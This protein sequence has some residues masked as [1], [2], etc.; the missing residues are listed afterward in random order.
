[1][2]AHTRLND[3]LGDENRMTSV[4]QMGNYLSFSVPR[5]SRPIDSCRRSL[6]RTQR[7]SLNQTRRN[8]LRRRPTTVSLPSPL[9]IPAPPSSNDESIFTP[10][11]LDRV[12]EEFGFPPV[13]P[14]E[15]PAMIT[16]TGSSPGIVEVPE[17]D[18]FFEDKVEPISNDVALG[19]V[20]DL[21]FSSGFDDYTFD[22]LFNLVNSD[23]MYNA[24]SP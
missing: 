4:N 8:I 13:E 2:E 22:S 21:E 23:V 19:I 6:R 12:V 24:P 1:M 3:L 15:H 17:L 9:D 5:E 20:Q 18:G 10:D 14:E 16:S 11:L 7:R